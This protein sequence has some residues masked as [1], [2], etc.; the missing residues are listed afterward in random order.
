MGMSGLSPMPV[1]AHIGG[2]NRGQFRNAMPNRINDRS[3]EEVIMPWVFRMHSGVGRAAVASLALTCLAMAGRAQQGAPALTDISP[4]SRTDPTKTTV[5]VTL[6]GTGLDATGAKLLFDPATVTAAGYQAVKGGTSATAT[7]TISGAAQ[8]V[9]KVSVQAGTFTSNSLPFNTGVVTD[10]CLDALQSGKCVLRFEVVATTATGNSTQT[11]NTTSPNILATLNWQV[12]SPSDPKVKRRTDIV[13]AIQ[14]MDALTIRK[15]AN[16][17]RGADNAKRREANSEKLKANAQKQAADPQEATA[18]AADATANAQEATAIVADAADIATKMDTA[19]KQMANAAKPTVSDRFAAHLYF[20]GGYTQV[21]AGHNVVQQTSSANS[22]GNA[23]NTST[24]QTSCTGTASTNSTS[25][26]AAAPA[27]MLATPQQAFVAEAGGTL[28][29]TM[30]I[31]SASF[32]EAGFGARGSFQDLVPGNQVVQNGGLTYIDLS[33]NNPKNVIGLYEATARFMIATVGQ[34]AATTDGS[35]HNTSNLLV[36]EA[37]YQNNS[38][39]QQLIPS[40]PQTN[41]RNR[42]VGRFYI[43][44]PVSQSTQTKLALGV[45]YSGGING[46][47]KVVQL[48]LGTNLNPGKLFSPKKSQSGT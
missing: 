35:Y 42:F 18:L 3:K 15:T 37:G 29:W 39:L 6:T 30:G 9:V 19:R 33:S 47:P 10:V 16:A 32:A 21:V 11:N 14:S 13:N 45:E 38:G 20:K 17:Q 7:L 46:G 23:G 44:P 5:S 41:T 22:T 43:Y 40:S 27:C 28:G 31:G 1:I 8:G 4:S 25:S 12:R 34:R 2:P 48:F 24:S 26:T 36:I